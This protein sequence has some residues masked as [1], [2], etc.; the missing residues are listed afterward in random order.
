MI[1]VASARCAK[2]T[3][4]TYAAAVFRPLVAVAA[5]L[6][7]AAIAAGCGGANRTP[8]APTSASSTTV[9]STADATACDE[10]ELDVRFISQ[11]ISNTVEAITN[12]RH[13]KQLA[14][15]TGVGQ[16]SLLVAVRLI[17]RFDA[18]PSLAT[19]R[20]QLE[21]GLRRYAADFGRAQRSVAKNDIAE[22]SRQ[23]SDPVAL[24]EVRRATA[25]IDRACGA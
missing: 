17:D 7:A 5:A 23:L 16:Q 1:A 3:P 11:L 14:R 24:A 13:P 19:P 25:A 8:T 10:V 4:V 2:R 22:A 15:R 6:A 21:H 20:A 12:S 9:T 18:P